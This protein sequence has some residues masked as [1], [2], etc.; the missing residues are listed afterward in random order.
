MQRLLVWP[1]LK[2][3]HPGKQERSFWKETRSEKKP[4]RCCRKRSWICW[5]GSW[6]P[7]R[8][9]RWDCG[10]LLPCCLARFPDQPCCEKSKSG[11]WAKRWKRNWNKKVD[12]SQGRHFAQA[13]LEDCVLVRILILSPT[14]RS[15]QL[16]DWDESESLKKVKVTGRRKSSKSGFTHVT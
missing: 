11:G 13:S 14:T 2:L 4:P 9:Q 1:L 10:S 5:G 12:K 3:L 15:I 16:L 7:S 6:W 8:S